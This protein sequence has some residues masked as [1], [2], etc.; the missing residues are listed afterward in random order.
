M[1]IDETAAFV[2]FSLSFSFGILAVSDKGCMTE[3]VGALS[4]P[5]STPPYLV[6]TE[7]NIARMRLTCKKT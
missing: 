4:Y 6:E 5:R 2:S 3:V 7:S 1:I